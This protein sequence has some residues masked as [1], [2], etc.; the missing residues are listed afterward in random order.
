KVDY[1]DPL[2]LIP[3][4]P[5]GGAT[6]PVRKQTKG[7][8]SPDM[9]EAVIVAAKRTPIG[10]AYRGAFNNTH[11]ATLAGEAIKAVVAQAGVD[12]GEIDD[13]VMGTA[14]QQGT[15]GSNISRKTALRWPRAGSA[16]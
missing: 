7:M 5:A 14:M 3:S 1:L 13:V 16:R 10:K 6:R 8:D 2:C 4:F 9:R 11:G 15:T 12:P